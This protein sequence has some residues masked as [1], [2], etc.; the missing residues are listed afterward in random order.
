[1]ENRLLKVMIGVTLLLLWT[2]AL[3][4]A[5]FVIENCVLDFHRKR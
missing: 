2:Q 1:M 5:M 3:S 4:M